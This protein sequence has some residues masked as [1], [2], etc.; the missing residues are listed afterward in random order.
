[1]LCVAI[2]LTQVMKRLTMPTDITYY[3]SCTL[4]GKLFVTEKAYEE[5]MAKRHRD[6]KVE[7]VLVPVRHHVENVTGPV[8]APPKKRKNR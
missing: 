2:D 1:M 4:C 3:L 8:V 6:C 5:H 7:R